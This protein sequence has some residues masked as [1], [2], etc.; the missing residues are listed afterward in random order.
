MRLD[1]GAYHARVEHTLG[2]SL[3]V[4]RHGRIRLITR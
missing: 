2:E 1:K 4:V 3:I